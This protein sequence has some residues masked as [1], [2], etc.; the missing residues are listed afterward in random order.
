MQIR[1]LWFPRRYVKTESYRLAQALQ[2]TT[3]GPDV[4]DEEI[5]PARGINQDHLLA[6]F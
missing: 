4:A 1:D 6:F 3:S 5:P 2:P